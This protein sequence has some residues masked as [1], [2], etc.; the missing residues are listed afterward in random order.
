MAPT[1]DGAG[2]LVALPHAF[3]KA[4]VKQDCNV[5]LPQP[6]Q[7]GVGMCFLPHEDK[8]LYNRAKGI[9]TDVAQGLGHDVLG[10]RRVP[11]D[12]V[13]VGPSA[14]ATQP[15][16]EQVFLSLSSQDTYGKTDAE[17][18]VTLKHVT[19]IME[20]SVL[21]AKLVVVESKNANTSQNKPQEF[22]CEGNPQ[23]KLQATLSAW[24]TANS[25]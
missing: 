18:Q 6:E 17:Q 13:G 8:D 23:Y 19:D 7:Y 9:I 14:L 4:V 21:F 20:V 11:T 1:G 15:V 22:K 2:C 16:V 10:W 24:I 5:E 12:P 25:K 3:L